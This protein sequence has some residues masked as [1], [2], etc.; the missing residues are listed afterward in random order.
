MEYFHIS[1]HCHL[2]P[3]SFVARLCFQEILKCA[4]NWPYPVLK[5]QVRQKACCI[6]SISHLYQPCPWFGYSFTTWTFSVCVCVHTLQTRGQTHKHQ[7]LSATHE[8]TNDKARQ[9]HVSS[10]VYSV[11]MFLIHIQL[12]L[13]PQLIA[14]YR[15]LTWVLFIFLPSPFIQTLSLVSSFFSSFP[16]NTLSLM[17]ALFLYFGR[18]AELDQY[19]SHSF[20][21]VALPCFIFKTL[22]RSYCSFWLAPSNIRASDASPS[23]PFHLAVASF[24][25]FH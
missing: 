14:V 18:G 3:V 23:S 12:N 19:S 13:R 6:L 25:C 20:C 10:L 9:P 15:S 1:C 5:A 2:K 7:L 22:F 11:R 24:F 21:S 16:Q 4:P 17:F 8:Q